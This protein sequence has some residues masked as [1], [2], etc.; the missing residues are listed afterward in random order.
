MGSSITDKVEF[1]KKYNF[2]NDR[3]WHSFREGK[4]RKFTLRKERF[5]LLLKDYRLNDMEMIEKINHYYL[6][7]C[8]IKPLLIKDSKEILNYLKAKYKLYIIS[9]GFYDVQLT[10][11]ISSGI[12]KYFTKVFTSDR[13]GYAKPHARMFEY[14][15]NSENTIKDECLMIGDD[16]VNDVEGA[17]NVQI[18]QVYFNPGKVKASFNATYEISELL[19][20]KKFL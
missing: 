11:M 1:V 19:E 3:L 14:A 17:R 2:Y 7:N 10:K 15:I 18:D 4:I 9:N 5:R 20:L 16:F 12:S 13:V 8:P 6:N